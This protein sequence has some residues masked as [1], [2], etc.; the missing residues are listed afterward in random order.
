MIEIPFAAD[1][2]ENMDRT[3]SHGNNPCIVCGRNI[4]NKKAKRVH[5]NSGFSHILTVEEFKAD[6]GE[7]GSWPVGPDCLNKHPELCE[8]IIE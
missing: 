8:Y 3:N 4:R 2:N 6:A 1:F 7:M 5:V